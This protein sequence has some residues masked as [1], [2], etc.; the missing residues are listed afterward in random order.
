MTALAAQQG[1]LLEALW[2]PG[3]EDAMSVLAPHL[4]GSVLAARGLKAYRSNASELACRA[5]AAVFPVVLQLL[6]EDN[7][8]HL[9]RD[10]W[11]AHPPVR[12]D[13]AQWGAGLAGHIAALPQLATEPFLPDVARTEWLLHEAASA[14]DDEAALASFGLLGQLEP[15]QVT[16]VLAPG[17]ASVVSPYPVASIVLSHVMGEPAIAEAGRRL[18]EGVQETALVWRRGLKPTLRKAFDGEA[19]FVGALKEKSSLADSLAAAPQLDFNQWLLVAA[20][21]GLALRAVPV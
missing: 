21:S 19:D 13:M 20:Q 10:F 11:Q 6:D 1:A 7:F 3:H 9:A 2:R 4:G 5:L 14:A 15:S 12:G 8:R 18:R 16:L 17:T